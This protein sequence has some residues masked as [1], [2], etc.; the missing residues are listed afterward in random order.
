MLYFS[1]SIYFYFYVI[2]FIFVLDSLNFCY[3]PDGSNG[4]EYHNLAQAL[5]NLLIKDKSSLKPENL[6][7]LSREDVKKDI[8][9]GI[10]FPLLDERWRILHEI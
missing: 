2:D 7:K 4:W 8:F 1:S 3:W 5:K 10:E 6:L 9:G